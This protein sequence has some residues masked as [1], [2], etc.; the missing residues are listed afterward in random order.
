MVPRL[1][2]Y[3]TVLLLP[4]LTSAADPGPSTAIG[5]LRPHP[6]NPCWFVRPDGQ[7]VWLTGSH[8]WANFQERGIEGQTPDFDYEGYLDFLERHGHNFIRL[9]S[10][11]QAQWMQF[12]D[13]GVPVR[14]KPHPYQRTGP[15]KALDGGLKFDLTEFNDEY[16]QRLRRR[17]ELA[18]ERGIYVSVMF[19]QGFSLDKRRGN[20]KAGNAWHGHPLNKA[21]N[22][23]AIDGNPSG[24]DSG[25][26]IHELKV[27]EITRL[28]EAFVRRMID[29]V[30]DLDNVLWE[31]GNECHSRS[32]EWQYHMIRYI[33]QIEST[34]AQQHPVGMTG[35]PIGTRELV[36]SP[37]DWIS[38]PGKRW[39]TDPPA[40]DG[41]KVILVDTDH[42]DPW[43]HDPDWVWKNLFRGNQFILM[44]GYVDY[45][46]GSPDQPDPKWDVTRQAMGQARKLAERIELAS[47]QPNSKLASTGFCLSTPVNNGGVF[48]CAV[49]LPKGG[50]ATVDLSGIKGPL[51]VEWIETTSN[52][53]HEA[54]RALGGSRQRF[55]APLAGPAVLWLAGSS[56]DT[57]LR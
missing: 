6:D 23:N 19:F 57:D 25:H 49:Y 27:P 31:I 1:L 54:A 44:D 14:Y 13:K 4:L 5:P 42:C 15:G 34:R 33:K 18:G 53:R 45:R 32:V 29:T 55:V 21:N 17:V 47:F 7:V 9:W 40:N 46:I 50:E 16:F 3:L 51:T 56:E 2:A 12:V 10:W 43:H 35:A 52:A 28:Q 8:T 11:E 24:D 37:A 48:R 30:G 38:P 39:L 22:I 41:T 26:E 36:A 20:A